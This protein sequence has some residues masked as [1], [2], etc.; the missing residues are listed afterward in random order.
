MMGIA[1]IFAI[2]YGFINKPFYLN[3]INGLTIVS[4]FMLLAGVIRWGWI[5]GDL[6]FFSWKPQDGSYRKWK[7]GRI[8]E[9]KDKRNNILKAAVV[10][11][12]I[13]LVLSFLY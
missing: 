12:V 8:A 5:E 9:H 11:V 10:L 7:E 6:A 4:M 3:F 2:I 13:S 1:F